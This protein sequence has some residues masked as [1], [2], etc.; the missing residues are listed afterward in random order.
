MN[1][2]FKK[3]SKI[4]NKKPMMYLIASCFTAIYLTALNFI[5]SL[6]TQTINTAILNDSLA[7]LKDVVADGGLA[8]LFTDGASKDIINSYMLKT[9][10]SGLAIEFVVSLLTA[11]LFLVLVVATYYSLKT[12]EPIFS[13]LFKKAPQKLFSSKVIKLSLSYIFLYAVAQ[14]IYLGFMQ[15]LSIKEL[16]LSTN[17]YFVVYYIFIGIMFA[18]SLSIFTFIIQ[19]MT[20]KSKLVENSFVGRFVFIAIVAV[21]VMTFWFVINYIVYGYFKFDP[22]IM[23]FKLILLFVQ[24]YTT[25]WTTLYAIHITFDAVLPLSKSQVN[26]LSST[27][28]DTEE[29]DGIVVKSNIRN[30]RYNERKTP[31]DRRFKE[32]SRIEKDLR[33]KLNLKKRA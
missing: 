18:F 32:N 29:Y 16:E 14:V 26:N 20:N 7:K 21:I 6:V 13:M 33:P 22:A 15:F 9:I 5:Q 28:D 27:Q 8:N 11:F 12:S 3:F 17:I 2:Y 31:K 25:A 19:K 24:L 4:F 10:T 30:I 23:S 1:N